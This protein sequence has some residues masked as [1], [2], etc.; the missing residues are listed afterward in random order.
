MANSGRAFKV[1]LYQEHLEEAAFLYAQR[2]RLRDDPTTSWRD[3]G[4][5][6]DRLEA[7]I[8]ALV[9]GEA[10]ALRVCRDRA[11]EGEPSELFPAMSVFCRQRRADL[12]SQVLADLDFADAERLRPVE[13]A[14][15]DELPVE[16]AA[17]C[18]QALVRGPA[19]LIPV[20]AR[21]AGHRRLPLAAH[22]EQALVDSP[23]GAVA[24]IAWARGRLAPGSRNPGLLRCLQH[25]NDAIRGAALL[26]LLRLG[27][28]EPLAACLLVAR[29]QAWP[30][31]A[32]GLGGSRQASEVLGEAAR[33]SGATPDTVLALGLLGNLHSL[34]M[35]HEC[36]ARP[37]LSESA[38]LALQLI[39]GAPLYEEVFVPDDVLEDEL[40]EHERTAWSEHGRAPTHDDGRPFGTIVRTLTCSPERWGAWISSHAGDFDA[41]YRYR[42]GQRYSPSVLLATLSDDSAPHRMRQLAADELVIRYGCDVPF[43]ADL[44]VPRQVALLL[45][46][47]QW[48]EVNTRRFEPGRW[49]FA[50]RAV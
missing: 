7:H 50:G 25:E 8:D 36:L 22:L 11:G 43:E 12:V 35:L 3:I 27:A 28:P 20:V 15:K 5:F 4:A 18:K 6:E 13:D 45:E 31:L 17:Y 37:G 49:Y 21:I 26:A 39:T 48:I 9:V 14:L 10:L 29:E 19:G 46:I 34:R 38:A 30:H 44:A 16:W 23:H 1:E 41:A 2:R 40:F 33:S 24:D 32:L 42:N 47:A